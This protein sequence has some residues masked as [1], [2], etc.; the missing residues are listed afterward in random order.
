MRDLREM[1]LGLAGWLLH[2]LRNFVDRVDN[3]YWTRHYRAR[4]G[5][6][7]QGLR[8]NGQGFIDGAGN[9]RIGDNV[10]IGRGYFIV[11]TGGLEIGDNT[12]VSRN[13]LLYTVNHDTRGRCL[14]YDD[15]Q[16]PRPVRVGRNVWIGMNVVILPG[17]VIGDGAIIGAGA[18]VHG[19]VAPLAIVGAA[20]QQVIGQRDREHYE[21]LERER[22]Y[23]GRSGLPLSPGGHDR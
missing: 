11:G 12:H 1:C 9:I 19:E 21:R 23:G 17:T 6:A 13:L 10:H 2:R 4:L 16:V 22:R 7:G 18:V 3:V 14:P 8:L 15:T 5:A 20:G